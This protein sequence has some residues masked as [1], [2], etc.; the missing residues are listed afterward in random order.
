MK[1]LGINILALSLAGMFLLS[2][3]GIR[4]L[5]HHCLSC[6]TTDIAL[7]AFAE[8]DF[9]HM[10]HEH[11]ST[12]SCHVNFE[13]ESEINCC[14]ANAEHHATTCSDCCK[15]EVH[16]LK[17]EYQVSQERN[18]QRLEPALLAVLLPL[19]NLQDHKL[20]PAVH[21][22]AQSCNTDPPKPVGREFLI[23]AHQ[24]KIAH[25][26]SINA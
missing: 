11:A 22:Y 23:F 7:F 16:Y 5:I 15:T 21:L 18:E 17:N 25:S 6:E 9:D 12:M 13:D 14:D 4:M 2:F 24:L 1:K 8:N 20:N 26:F 10:H 3:T 19:I